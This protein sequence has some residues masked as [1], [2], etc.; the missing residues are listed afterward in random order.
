MSDVIGTFE[1]SFDGSGGMEGDTSITATRTA[2]VDT[3]FSQS[4]E[5]STEIPSFGESGESLSDDEILRGIRYVET[6]AGRRTG[7]VSGGYSEKL[8]ATKVYGA[9]QIMPSVWGSAIKEKFG[10]DFGDWYNEDPNNRDAVLQKSRQDRIA[11]ELLLP[12]YK[13]Q[14]QSQNLYQT[15]LGRHLP[16]GSLEILSQLGTGHLR[17][18]LTSGRDNTAYEGAKG[19]QIINYLNKSLGLF[20]KTIPDS[21]NKELNRLG[22]VSTKYAGL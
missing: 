13:Q 6:V 8:D 19:G 5:G 12:S 9:Y 11:R 3:P 20:G 2:S 21:F 1:V 10:W 14:I 17:T 16:K 15:P 22:G 7:G 4:K 18:F